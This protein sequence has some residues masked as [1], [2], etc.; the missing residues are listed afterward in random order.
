MSEIPGLT[1]PLNVDAIDDNEEEEEDDEADDEDE[2]SCS[3]EVVNSS[4]T[5]LL[6]HT[7]RLTNN[8]VKDNFLKQILTYFTRLDC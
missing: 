8:Y 1:S 2:K 7:N 6:Q 3:D 4:A 5:S